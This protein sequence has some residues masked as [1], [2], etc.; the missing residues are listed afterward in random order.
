MMDASRFRQR[1]VGVHNQD[2]QQEQSFDS[3][4]AYHDQ[5]LWLYELDDTGTGLDD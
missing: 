5:K 1:S 3:Y 4:G 2:D